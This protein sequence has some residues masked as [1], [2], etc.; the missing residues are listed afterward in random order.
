M[1]EECNFKAFNKALKDFIRCT[2]DSFPQYVELKLLL[3]TYKMLKTINKKRPCRLFQNMTENC[4]DHI[5]SKDEA[6]FQEN[7]IQCPDASVQSVM[8]TMNN[9]WSQLDEQNKD[10]VWQH[11]QKLVLLSKK[12]PK[13]DKPF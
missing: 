3:A 9:V 1:D 2:M 8:Q 4:Q 10:A 13:I 11:L 6:F 5:L 12:C 7:G